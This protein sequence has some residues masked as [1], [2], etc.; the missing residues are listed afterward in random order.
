MDVLAEN[1]P[2]S[3]VALGIVMLAI[4]VA[5]LGFA[6]FLMFFIGLSLV[7]T[8]SLM[9]LDILPQTWG[10]ILLANAIVSGLLAIALWKPLRNLQNKSEVK[11]VKSDFD[12][13]RFFCDTPIDSKGL[14]TH[15]YSGITWKLKSETPIPAGAE[16]EVVKAEVGTFWV[17]AV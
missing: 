1:I 8:G 6:T 5:I 14:S 13:V 16:V 7:I 12:G 17:K 2:Q 10:S 15:T 4:E 3:L 11:S 9:W